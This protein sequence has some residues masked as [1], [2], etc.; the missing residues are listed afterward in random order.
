MRVGI[1]VT[2]HGSHPP[3]KWAAET[4]AQIADVIVIDPTSIVFDSMSAAKSQ[5]Q[6]DLEKA[7]VA[8]HGTVQSHEADA[9]QEHGADRYDHPIAPEDDH[10][11]EAVA[12]VS[13]VAD[14]TM[15]AS[16]FRK[17]DVQ[18]FVRSTLH[19]H[20]ATVRQIERSWHLDKNS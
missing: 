18:A 3:H 19:S 2:N 1:L 5:F 10:I 7:L 16:H 4:A 20:F 14:K 13:A 9:L 6:E 8:S 12:A 17:P 11:N 15:F